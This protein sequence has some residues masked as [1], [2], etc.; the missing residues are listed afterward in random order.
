MVDD[1]CAGGG[2]GGLEALEWE[3]MVASVEASAAALVSRADV[4]ELAE[5]KPRTSP[6]WAAWSRTRKSSHFFCPSG[7]LGSVTF[8]NND[9]PG[10]SFKGKVLKI[11]PM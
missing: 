2:G 5:A 7:N 6:S 1:K 9:F 3:G 10:T 8:E 11:M 4:A